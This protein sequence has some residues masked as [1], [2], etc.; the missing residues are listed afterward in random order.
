MDV[1]ARLI[2]GETRWSNGFSNLKKARTSTA[3]HTRKAP[4]R[5]SVPLHRN[6]K[7]SD[8]RKVWAVVAYSPDT[9]RLLDGVANLHGRK[10]AV[11]V[12]LHLLPRIRKERIRKLSHLRLK[13]SIIFVTALA[14]WRWNVERS[15]YVP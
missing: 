14:T 8:L 7:G 1:K 15:T 12:R 10:Y 2:Q 4:T 6:I 13:A 11:R 5:S 9:K 3:F